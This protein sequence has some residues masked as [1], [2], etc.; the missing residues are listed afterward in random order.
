MLNMSSGSQPGEVWLPRR[1]IWWCQDKFLVVHA[2]GEGGEVSWHVMSRGQECYFLAL[3][4]MTVPTMKNYWSKM[5]T[6]PKLRNPAL[7]ITFS[8]HWL[9]S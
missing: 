6:V 7:N 9:T 1:E 3:E 8:S 2:G 5:S 4:Y